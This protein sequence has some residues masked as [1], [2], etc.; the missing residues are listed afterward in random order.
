MA[1]ELN[2]V[3]S[4]EISENVSSSMSPLEAIGDIN[5]NPGNGYYLFDK[6]CG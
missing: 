3:G 5:I 4:S 2:P 1:K 6:A